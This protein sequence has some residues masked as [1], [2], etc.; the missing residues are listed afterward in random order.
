MINEFDNDIKRLLLNTTSFILIFIF[1]VSFLP[2][3]M[4]SSPIDASLNGFISALKFST[5]SAE[6]GKWIG[7]FIFNALVAFVVSLYCGLCRQGRKWFI[8]FGGLF[9]FGVLIEYFQLFIDSRGT[10]LVD[11]YSNIAGLFV[12]FL[13]WGWFGQFTV[14]ALRYYYEFETLPLNFVRKIYLAFV[15]AIILFPFDFYFTPLQFEI[16]FA[17][18]G[19]PLFELDTGEGIGPI[20]ILAASVLTFPIGVLYRLSNSSAKRRTSR[21][22][23]IFAKFVVLF[24]FLEILQFFEVSG[25]SSLVSLCAKYAGFSIGFI[26]GRFFELK[27]LLEMALKFRLLIYIGL[28]IFVGLA[29][30]LKGLTF[31][32]PLSVSA[33]MDIIAA[34]SFLPFRYYIDVGSGEALLSFLLNFVIFMP[35]GAVMAIRQIAC[36]NFKI[37]SFSSLFGFG[38]LIALMFEILVLLWGLKRP[39]VTNILVSAFAMPVGYYFVI[40]CLNSI[41]LQSHQQNNQPS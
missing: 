4:E 19:M 41:S 21:T 16:A 6:P 23:N 8:V 34:T 25:Q 11:I 20:S 24:L 35:L 18:K 2:Y 3:N 31:L 27:F 10:S 1:Y 15:I 39:D 7:H 33:S 9:L 22:I 29:L 14:S 28:I 5:I 17:A 36:G 37:R 13:L 30:K 26:V 32:F 38:L 40:M 12:G